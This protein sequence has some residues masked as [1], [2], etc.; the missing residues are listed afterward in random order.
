[1]QKA[2]PEV[3]EAYQVFNDALRE[4][5]DA[6]AIL[7]NDSMFATSLLVEMVKF[8]QECIAYMESHPEF[9][10]A[11][12]DFY[13]GIKSISPL[14]QQELQKRK[15]LKLHHLNPQVFHA[16]MPNFKRNAPTS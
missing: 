1:M 9:M 2:N 8:N 14:V 12:R 16:Y 6:E 5:P 3:V 15:T 11:N 7:A 4:N 13:H 10:H